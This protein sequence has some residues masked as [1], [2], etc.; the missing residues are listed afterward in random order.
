MK[1]LFLAITFIAIALNGCANMSK[2]HQAAMGAALGGLAGAGLG[3]PLAANR[4]QR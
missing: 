2:E 3:A 4:E 1:R